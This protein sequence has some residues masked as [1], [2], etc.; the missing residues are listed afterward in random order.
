MVNEQLETIRNE[1][2]N[3][4][5]LYGTENITDLLNVVYSDDYVTSIYNCRGETS[6]L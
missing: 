6:Q 3:V 2:V 1:L 5:K 4:F